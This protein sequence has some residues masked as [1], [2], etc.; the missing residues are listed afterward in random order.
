MLDQS[1]I[2]W[3]Q[4]WLIR[5]RREEPITPGEPTSEEE[6]PEAFDRR[7]KDVCVLKGAWKDAL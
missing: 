2:A 6:K 7:Q 1:M 5:V 4:R 3:F